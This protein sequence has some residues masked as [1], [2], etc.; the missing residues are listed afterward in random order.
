LWRQGGSL[1]SEF[2]LQALDDKGQAISSKH[3]GPV[4][5]GAFPDS[6]RIVESIA[7]I[8]KT[9]ARDDALNTDLLAEAKQKAEGMEV[10]A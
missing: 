5:I 2:D 3:I 8:A 9:A 1:L 7:C 10:A 6:D 4:A